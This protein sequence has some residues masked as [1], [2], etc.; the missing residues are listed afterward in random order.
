MKKIAALFTALALILGLCTCSRSAAATWQEQYDLG[1]RYLSE[2]N[3][4]EAIIVFNAAIEIDPKQA[5]AYIGLADAYVAQGDTELARQVLA[6]ALAVVTDADAIRSRLDKLEGGA[7]PGTAPGATVEPTQEPEPTPGPS[8]TPTP[9]PPS[10]ATPTPTL[11]PTSTPEPAP[12]TYVDPLGGN[13]R[14][15]NI[16][17]PEGE[18]VNYQEFFYDELGRKSGWDAYGY[19]GYGLNWPLPPAQ[20][21]EHGEITY[22]SQNRLERQQSYDAD[23]ILLA[24]MTFVYNNVF[25]TEAYHYTAD[26]SEVIHL[27]YYY[28]AQGHLEKEEYYDQDSKTGGYNIFEHDE[29]GN[30]IRSTD[31]SLDGIVVGYEFYVYE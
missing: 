4:R 12:E 27:I 28:D 11:T 18:L 19:Y 23:G 2:G 3:Y 10:T 24:Y 22:D 29:S 7:V 21:Y 1:I 16:Y 30:I 25:L 20:L 5:D 15:I 31:Y 6:D 17:S 13:Y 9:T 14:R 8:P 26:G